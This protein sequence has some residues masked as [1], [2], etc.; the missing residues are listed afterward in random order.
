MKMRGSSVTPPSSTP[1][2][3]A[4]ATPSRS[5]GVVRGGS[6][7]WRR[8]DPNPGNTRTPTHHDPAVASKKKIIGN[9]NPIYF[10]PAAP[11]R[12][13]RPERPVRII[14]ALWASGR[15]GR[16]GRLGAYQLDPTRARAAGGPP[17]RCPGRVHV[18]RRIHILRAQ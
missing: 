5:F 11:R 17:P 9:I 10:R 18:L 15:T 16:T 14:W 12:P 2:K 13:R 3:H 6:P 1:M 8:P 4:Y 7:A